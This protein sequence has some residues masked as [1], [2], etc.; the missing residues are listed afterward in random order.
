M[1]G[2]LYEVGSVVENWLTGGE[3]EGWGVL[4]GTYS[5]CEKRRCLVTVPLSSSSLTF[6]LSLKLPLPLLIPNN[7]LSHLLYILHLTNFPRPHLVPPMQLP[8][9]L[10]VPR[11][12]GSGRGNFEE[13][14]GAAEEEE[15]EGGR[16]CGWE[17]GVRG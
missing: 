5:T 4:I 11:N 15:G 13:E 2:V 12:G 17:E 7:E 9:G 8:E 6:S 3:G 16:S 14:A 10:L 1:T